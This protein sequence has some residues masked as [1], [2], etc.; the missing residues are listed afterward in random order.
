MPPWRSTSS[1]KSATHGRRSVPTV[2]CSPRK[3]ATLGSTFH[4]D[5]T[6]GRDDS[7]RRHA[8][9]PGEASDDSVTPPIATPSIVEGIR[10]EGP[11]GCG[12]VGMGATRRAGGVAEGLTGRLLASTRRR[13]TTQ[14]WKAK[15]GVWARGCASYNPEGSW[16]RDGSAWRTGAVRNLDQRSIG[17]PTEVARPRADCAHGDDR[18]P[19]RADDGTGGVIVLVGQ[20]RRQAQLQWRAVVRGGERSRRIAD[21]KLGDDAAAEWGVPGNVLRRGRS[22]QDCRPAPCAA[23]PRQLCE[24]RHLPHQALPV[25]L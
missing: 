9:V 6:A 24:A 14:R 13:A 7:Q 23:A 8:S 16:D 5:E 1:A 19:R 10:F 12:P 25:G 17:Q 15:Q 22:P 20:M 2:A 18:D 3:A 11:L 21:D 4:S